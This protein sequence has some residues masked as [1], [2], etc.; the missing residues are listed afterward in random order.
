[1]RMLDHRKLSKKINYAALADLFADG[2]AG[3]EGTSG[4]PPEAAEALHGDEDRGARGQAVTAAMRER[5]QEQEREEA[6]RQARQKAALEAER[7]RVRGLGLPI[8]GKLGGK[9]TGLLGARS[10]LGSIVRRPG[11]L[12]S[13]RDAPLRSQAT[14]SGAGGS[15]KKSVR[16]AE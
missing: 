13:L 2:A 16:F 6:A 15:A 12:G 8:G 1:M 11:G 5:K 14:A 3:G 4:E 10:G 7:R 9:G